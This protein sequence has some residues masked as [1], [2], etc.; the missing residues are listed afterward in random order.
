[1]QTKTVSTRLSEGE[2]VLLDDMA[3]RKGLDRAAM[4][5]TL[6]RRGLV[7]LRFDEAVAAYRSSQV[8]LSRAAEIGGVSVWDFI[9]RMD[10]QDLTLHYGVADLEEDLSGDC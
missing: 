7:Q 5:K 6:L 9:G 10:E 2:L 4:T 8:T 1:M 3:L